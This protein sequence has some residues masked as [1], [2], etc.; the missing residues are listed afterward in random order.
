MVKVTLFKWAGRWG[1]FKIKIPCGECAITKDVI[2]DTLATELSDIA[3]D[4]ETKEWLSEWWRPLLKG[5]WHAPIVMVE[6]RVVSQGMA[7][8]RGLFAEA[9]IKEHCKEST[10]TGN[11]LFGKYGC[12]QCERA[13]EALEEAGIEYQYHDIIK[14]PA[15]LYEMMARVK[16][17]I[18]AKTPVTVP[19]VWMDGKY[20]G[21][22]DNL[23]K[24]VKRRQVSA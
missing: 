17:V 5:G 19:Q 1:P 15:A 10:I 12:P 22:A 18:G 21:G 6:G 8:N 24:V 9:V 11:H 20:V 3:V 13:K 14:S 2:A 16:P 7:L 23:V 4:V